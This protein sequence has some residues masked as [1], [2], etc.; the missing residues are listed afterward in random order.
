MTFGG[1]KRVKGMANLGLA[2][3]LRLLE[4]YDILPLSYV[5]ALDYSGILHVH[6]LR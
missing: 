6:G 5:K 2:L 3:G 1:L 4:S